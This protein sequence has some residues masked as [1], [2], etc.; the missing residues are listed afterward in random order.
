[1]HTLRVVLVGMCAVAMACDSV[2]PTPDDLKPPGTD[3]PDMAPP[4][5]SMPDLAPDLTPTGDMTPVYDLTPDLTPSDNPSTIRGLVDALAYWACINEVRCKRLTISSAV[6]PAMDQRF[7][8]CKETMRG[9]I[10]SKLSDDNIANVLHAD[11]DSEMHQDGG[12]R[13]GLNLAIIAAQKNLECDSSTDG[14]LTYINHHAFTP[15]VAVGGPC[16]VDAECI[17]GYCPR[18]AKMAGGQLPPGCPGGTCNAFPDAGVAC[19]LDVTECGP[20]GLNRC[21]AGVC[22]ARGKG[23][24]Q[25][26]VYPGSVFTRCATATGIYCQ[27]GITGSGTCATATASSAAGA[28]CDPLQGKTTQFPSCVKGYYCN[29]R[30]GPD[31]GV[32]GGAANAVCTTR[33]PVGVNATCDPSDCFQD[34]AM[35]YYCDPCGEGEVCS[36]GHC[37]LDTK[38]P[39]GVACVDDAHCELGTFCNQTTFKCQRK[40][41][42]G[43]RIGNDTMGDPLCLLGANSGSQYGTASICLSGFC[44]ARGDGKYYCTNYKMPGDPCVGD[45]SDDVSCTTWSAGQGVGSYNPANQQACR[46]VTGRDA[47]MCGLGCN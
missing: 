47:G 9:D 33:K 42:N 34:G 26:C 45:G 35:V 16:A 3:M 30:G 24:G 32:D 43:D 20:T 19:T 27:G 8:D 40:N 14:V 17:N 6:Q 31:A 4:D 21:T 25:A 46:G 11:I 7:N 23:A 22:V 15:L 29:L 1:M 18:Q 38:S 39:D 12:A 10:L 44:E 36:S 13:L 28:G 37:K 5:L 41:A 2:L